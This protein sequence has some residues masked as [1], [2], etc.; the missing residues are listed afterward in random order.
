MD[1]VELGLARGMRVRFRRDANDRWSTAIVEQVEKDGSLGLRDAKGASRAIPVELVEV[2]TRGPRGARTWEP[3][4]E[5]AARNE[6]LKL[7]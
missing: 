5:R 2:E 3:V 1:L 4:S 6:Q 7:L